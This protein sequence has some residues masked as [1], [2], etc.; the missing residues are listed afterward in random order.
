[1]AV[2]E[3]GTLATDGIVVAAVDVVRQLP[4]GLATSGMSPAAMMA[5][6]RLRGKIRVT[7]RGMWVDNGRLIREIHDA[8]DRAMETLPPDARCAC[9]GLA[10]A[11]HALAASKRRDACADRRCVCAAS[12]RWSAW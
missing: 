8:A 2:I 6:A 3:R 1:M 10:A 5:A 9:D 11:E 7:T 4:R 12:S